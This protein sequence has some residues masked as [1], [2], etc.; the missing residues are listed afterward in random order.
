MRKRHIAYRS[1]S[2][3]LLLQLVLTISLW[4]SPSYRLMWSRFLT[5]R[6]WFF[7][8]PPLCA[9][10]ICSWYTAVHLNGLGRLYQ[11][12]SFLQLYIH[13][14][15]HAAL[16]NNFDRPNASPARH[17]TLPTFA[18]SSAS[19]TT[20]LLRARA[21][22]R[23]ASY[24]TSRNAN[25]ATQ[26]TALL[27]QTRKEANAIVHSVFR[28]IIAKV[29]LFLDHAAIHIKRAADRPHAS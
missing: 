18:S 9:W 27:S 28:R 14:G 11:R 16:R 20:A 10:L 12:L 23:A 3:L 22:R 5:R 1:P 29:A 21:I 15:R 8:E 7:L 17:G 25:A 6:F 26:H 13:L 24:T 19:F 4:G 2:M